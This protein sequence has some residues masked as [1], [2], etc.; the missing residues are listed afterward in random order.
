MYGSTWSVL[1]TLVEGQEVALTGG[2]DIVSKDGVFLRQAGLLVL[3]DLPEPEPPPVVEQ[4][5]D[6]K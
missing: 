5:P 4:G 6:A 2:F 3:D 1:P